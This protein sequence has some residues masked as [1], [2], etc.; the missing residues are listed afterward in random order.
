MVYG[1]VAAFV[2]RDDPGAPFARR[3]GAERSGGCGWSRYSV[4]EDDPVL[5][6]RGTAT[7]KGRSR[8]PPLRRLLPPVSFSRSGGYRRRGAGRRAPV[9]AREV[10]AAAG[11]SALGVAAAPTVVIDAVCRSAVALIDASVGGTRS[12]S[13]TLRRMSSWWSQCPWGSPALRMCVPFLR[14][15]TPFCHAKKQPCGCFFFM[16]IIAVL[17][18]NRLC[19]KGT[20]R[21]PM[22]FIWAAFSAARAS[23]MAILRMMLPTVCISSPPGR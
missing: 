2:G 7:Q 20:S 15:A 22:A 4:G 23:A 1:S 8:A 9:T 17:Y 11:T 18:S 6:G 19:W 14:W 13:D 12:A 21:W 16:Q 3:R 5:P 10:R